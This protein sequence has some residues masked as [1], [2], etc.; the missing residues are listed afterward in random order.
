MENIEFMKPTPIKIERG[1]PMP[2]RGWGKSD[3]LKKAFKT[4]KAGDSFLWPNRFGIYDCAKK[5][6]VKI[7]TRKE[8]GLGFRV[9]RVS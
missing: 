9:W 7:A 8:S 2:Q 3:A 5:A 6:G 1:V 4:M